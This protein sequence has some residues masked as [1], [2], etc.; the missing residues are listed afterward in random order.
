MFKELNT[1]KPFLEEPNREFNVREAARMLKIAPATASKKLKKLAKEGILKERKDRFLN[2]YRADMENS[3]YLDLKVYY[4]I[5]K[6]RESGLRDSLN[7][8]YIKPAI[9][10]FGSAAYGMDTKDSDIDLFILSEK[11]GK[12]PET[13]KFEK[14]INRKIQ[15]FAEKDINDLKNEH[16]IN[17]VLNGIVLQGELRWI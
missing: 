11:T 5:R 15:I 16:L 17:N 1:I 10:L 6:I 7:R 3:Q 4:T 13:S 8:F 12:P 14:I 2:L 9:V